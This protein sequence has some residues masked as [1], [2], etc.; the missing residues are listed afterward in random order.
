MDL[1]DLVDGPLPDVLL[2]PLQVDLRMSDSD[3]V[4][5]M[6]VDDSDG[7]THVEIG[8][9]SSTS[10]SSARSLSCVESDRD[11]EGESCISEPSILRRIGSRSNFEATCGENCH[12][13]VLWKQ[14]A[15][16]SS[17]ASPLGQCC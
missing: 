14:G 5:S 16:S 11:R 4:V 17:S 1:A 2:E 9:A 6:Q 12:S 15:C 3:D 7:E 13:E 10:G 8:M